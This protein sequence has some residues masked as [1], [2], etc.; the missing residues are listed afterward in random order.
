M[1]KSSACELAP[2]SKL[3]LPETAY[4]RINRS[5]TVEV[6]AWGSPLEN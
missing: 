6:E 3:L 5:R 2:L 1:C 4:A